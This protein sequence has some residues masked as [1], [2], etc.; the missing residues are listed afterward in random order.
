MRV[1]CQENAGGSN[2]S[3]GDVGLWDQRNCPT[4]TRNRREH[5]V[6]RQTWSKNHSSSVGYALGLE[7]INSP[8]VVRP[9][10]ALEIRILVVVRFACVGV[11]CCL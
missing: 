11:T 5:G 1:S 4:I 8:I 9:V 6:A 3:Y 7:G 2:G 10:V